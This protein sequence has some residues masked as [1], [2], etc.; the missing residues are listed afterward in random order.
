MGVPRIYPVTDAMIILFLYRIHGAVIRASINASCRREHTADQGGRS[1]AD[2]SNPAPMGYHTS[3]GFCVEHGSIWC[4]L[5][6]ATVSNPLSPDH[7]YLV[8]SWL[9]GCSTHLTLQNTAKHIAHISDKYQHYSEGVPPVWYIIS[10][11][12]YT[13]YSGTVLQTAV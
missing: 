13:Q 12:L 10:L 11:H 4:K 1:A 7:F 8:L 5:Y 2:G 3:I 9:C 6:Y